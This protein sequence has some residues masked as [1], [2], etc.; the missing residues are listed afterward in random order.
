MR[1]AQ[2]SSGKTTLITYLSTIVVKNYSYNIVC[3]VCNNFTINHCT[4]QVFLL[5]YICRN[6]FSQ[7]V[8]NNLLVQL[9]TA[10][11]ASER[12]TGVQ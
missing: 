1:D 12:T 7:S 9:K 2:D 8:M 5:I 3:N 4:D 6:L 11:I 10:A